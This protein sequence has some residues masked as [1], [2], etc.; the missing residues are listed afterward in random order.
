MVYH[1]DMAVKIQIDIKAV[2]AKL[3]ATLSDDTLTRCNKLAAQAVADLG[4]RAFSE[5]DIRPEPWPDYAGTESGKRYA[6]RK[7]GKGR[8]KMLV[9]EG[10]LLASI[11]AGSAAPTGAEVVSS[12]PYAS[13]H[14]FGTSKM[15]PRPFMPFTGGLTG[16]AILTDRA[17]QNVDDVVEAVIKAAIN[18]GG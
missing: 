15:P 14:Q 17:Q 8:D 9:D 10:L 16:A 5:T 3:D 12:R 2:A 4:T 7:I 18:R 11:K 1:F 13:Y 6:K